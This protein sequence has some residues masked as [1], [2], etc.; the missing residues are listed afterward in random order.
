MGHIIESLVKKIGLSSNQL[1]KC[2][3]LNTAIELFSYVDSSPYSGSGYLYQDWSMDDFDHLYS[4]SSDEQQILENMDTLFPSLDR[5]CGSSPEADTA[6]MTLIDELETMYLPIPENLCVQAAQ[7]SDASDPNPL[8]LTKSESF[9]YLVGPVNLWLEFPSDLDTQAIKSPSAKDFLLPADISERDTL[10]V[11]R[12][13][14]SEA[15]S[16]L[17]DNYDLCFS[18]SPMEKV[19]RKTWETKEQDFFNIEDLFEWVEEEM[20]HLAEQ[21]NSVVGDRN[22]HKTTTKHLEEQP[23]SSTPCGERTRASVQRGGIPASDVHYLP[24]VLN[25]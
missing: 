7:G 3:L 23:V 20:V 6:C 24:F 13:E 5:T 19:H 10:S 4:A 15:E 14:D 1:L 25:Y 16:I 9:Y 12:N 2:V 11:S 18:R 8:N 21:D 17:W 22:P